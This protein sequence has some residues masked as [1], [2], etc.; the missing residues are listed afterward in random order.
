M[1]DV[2]GIKLVVDKSPEENVSLSNRAV[3]GTT[4]PGFSRSKY[5]LKICTHRPKLYTILFL[6]QTYYSYAYV[7][8][9]NNCYVTVA[10]DP[11]VSAGKVALNAKQVTSLYCIPM[12]PSYTIYNVHII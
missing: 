7:V 12:H 6:L 5:V 3:V 4:Q 1:S 2:T 11:R 9:S 8:N 10:T